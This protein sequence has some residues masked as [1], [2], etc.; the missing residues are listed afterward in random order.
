MQSQPGG[1]F[2]CIDERAAGGTRYLFEIDGLSRV[3]D[4]AS[5][6]Q[7]EGPE[8]PS[9]VVDPRDFDW[10]TPFVPRPY[11]ENVIYE[12][13]V[14]TYTPEGTYAAAAQRLDHL[15]DL[16]ITAIEL[17]PLSEAPG[18]RNW[19]YDGVLHYAPSHNYGTPDDLKRFIVAAHARGLAVLLD[20]VYN[21]FGPQGNMLHL[22]APQ[23]FS[24][25]LKTPWGA[26]IDYASPSNDA[27]RRYAIENAC[28]W[29]VEYGFDGLR[30]D[31]TPMI[32]DNRPEHILH[33]LLLEAKRTA[34]RPVYLIAED[35]KNEVIALVA[36]Y[37][38]RWSDDTHDALH[39]ALTNDPSPYYRP[40]ATAPI[41]R[42][43]TALTTE[44]LHR[45]QF[46]QN[47]DQVGNRPFGERLTALAAPEAMRAATAVLLLAPSTPLLFMGEEWGA[48][49]PFL[50]FCDFEPGLA[51]RVREGR[52]KE[53]AGLA[54]FND[55]V[56][57]RTIPDPSA[58]ET[59]LASKLDWS[60]PARNEH[61]AWLAFHRELLRIRREAVVP[62]L[63]N[64]LAPGDTPSSRVGERGLV[65]TWRFTNGD[66]LRLEANL[67]DDARSGF[68][69]TRERI[70]YATHDEA[71]ADGTA[72]PWSV[73]WSRGE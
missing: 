37:D 34:G 23:F 58:I 66:L 32:L 73:R 51:Q 42:L 52:A 54:E 8:G 43:G 28:Y 29:L 4:P 17:M 53:F 35:V 16:G 30:L 56:K 68:T 38:G 69:E 72:P 33:E 18:T 49:T 27:V 61:A 46:L 15:V 70:I 63:A 60:E 64:G 1:W 36:P 20:V 59:F 11:H 71:F 48:S 57:R 9:R 65:A 24:E 40:F 41:E 25:R 13:H 44:V 19:G 31:A 22:Y 2:E 47:H 12:L 45:V 39:V 5:R 50:F 21:H 7:P 26:G 10:P 62:L 3:A 55:P 6:F 67:G 14:G